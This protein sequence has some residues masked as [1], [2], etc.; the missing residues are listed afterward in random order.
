MAFHSSLHVI[1]ENTLLLLF[2]V[3]SFYFVVLPVTTFVHEFGHALVG[4]SIADG[5]VI[6]SVGDD[7]NISF[8]IGRLVVLISPTKG[9]R[10]LCYYDNATG[11]I[12]GFNQ[13][14]FFVSGPIASLVLLV[15]MIWL[16][17]VDL[18]SYLRPLLLV[19]IVYTSVILFVTLFPINIQESERISLYGIQD[20]YISDGYRAVLA[21]TTA[22]RGPSEEDS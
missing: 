3:I 21:I 19:S 14:I 9:Y 16:W 6:L 13:F 10:G 2:V 15:A 11:E 4:L 17:T 5:V 12:S 1:V 8:S 18:N 7:L 20:T 22:R